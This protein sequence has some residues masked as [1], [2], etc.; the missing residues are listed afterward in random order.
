[1]GFK[2]FG[3]QN[4]AAI[5]LLSTL[6]AISSVGVGYA[7]KVLSFTPLGP[8]AGQLL[9]GLHV[10]WLILVVAVVRNRGSAFVAGALMGLIEMVLPNH[11]GPFVFFMALLEGVVIELAL[12][13][14]RRATQAAMVFAA[15]FSSASNVLV[16][17][18]FEILP[19]SFPMEVYAAM[20]A[21]SFLSG[22]AL[23]GYLSVRS[24]DALERF[25]RGSW[26]ADT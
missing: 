20:Y 15:G 16:L 7:G 18:V 5:A 8:V 11:L 25:I 6:G 3:S 24:L 2:K 10:F 9:A 4:L 12:L 14:F 21:A 26:R 13:P 19:V 1:M 22:L 17:Q 23:G